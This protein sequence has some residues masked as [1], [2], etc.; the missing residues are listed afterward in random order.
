MCVPRIQN[1]ECVFQEYKT[2][3]CVSMVQ[4]KECVS[5]EYKTKNVCSKN[6]KQKCVFQ[7][8]KTI[9]STISVNSIGY[10]VDICL[11]SFRYEEKLQI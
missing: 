7:E 10:A 4:N 3:M 1:N 11:F 6:R 9:I 8:F 5:Q 2:K